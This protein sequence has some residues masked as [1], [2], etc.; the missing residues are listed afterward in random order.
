MFLIKVPKARCLMHSR[1]SKET[2][3]PFQLKGLDNKVFMMK[4]LHYSS[5]YSICKSKPV[6]PKRSTDFSDSKSFQK[7]PV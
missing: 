7:A 3:T 5:L 4:S 6:D 2:K 1:K